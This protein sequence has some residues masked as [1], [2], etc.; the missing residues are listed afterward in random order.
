M[1]TY[2]IKRRDFITL[3]GGMAGGVVARRARAAA[4]KEFQSL[5][6]PLVQQPDLQAD[7]GKYA[8]FNSLYDE[9]F[10]FGRHNRSLVCR[11]RPCV[12]K[13]QRHHRLG[14]K[15]RRR[16]FPNR[17]C[18]RDNAGL[19]GSANDGDGPRR[20]VRRGQFDRAA[21]P[22]VSGAA[23]CGP[24]HVKGSRRCGGSRCGTG[25]N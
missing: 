3:V 22:T 17:A 24:G 13:R 21:L 2:S 9:P 18:R 4:S 15:S 1:A 11:R 7:G 19:H 5:E 14:R 6:I 8:C 25:D 20:D 10:G 23:P 16:R 12:G